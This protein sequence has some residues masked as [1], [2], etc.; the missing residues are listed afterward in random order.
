MN[1]AFGSA[2]GP[3]VSSGPPQPMMRPGYGMPPLQ[4]QQQPPRSYAPP[5][6]AY[7]AAPGAAPGQPTAPGM[8]P[9]GG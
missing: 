9:G 2:G 8:P 4:Q 5:P 3:G 1:P 6:G 7:M